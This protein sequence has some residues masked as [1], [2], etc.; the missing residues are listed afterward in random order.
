MSQIPIIQE[1]PEKPDRQ[2][3]DARRELETPETNMHAKL[4]DPPRELGQL[5]GWFV[6]GLCSY[7]VHTVLI[8]I[9]FP[10]LIIE[11]AAPTSDLT[12]PAHTSRGVACSPEE[13]N[14]Q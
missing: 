6:Y 2:E 1:V 12:P 14:L 10:L 11:R 4:E 9:L 8:P 5:I 7:F 13:L 3:D